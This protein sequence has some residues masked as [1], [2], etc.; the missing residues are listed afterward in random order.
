[1]S[2]LVKLAPLGVGLVVFA[3]VVAFVVQKNM[4]IGPW[5]IAAFLLGHGLVHIMFATPPPANPADPASEFAFDVNRSWAVTARVVDA[6]VLRVAV[7]GLV[8]ITVVGYG[9]AAFATVG[10]A[11]PQTLWAPLVIASTVASAALMVIGLSPALALGIAI[12]VALL[13]LV[14]ASVWLPGRVVPGT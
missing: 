5:L 14:V 4:A 3:V 6:Q 10:I 1:M 13:W 8:A 2:A 11:L 12:D 7:M 9:L